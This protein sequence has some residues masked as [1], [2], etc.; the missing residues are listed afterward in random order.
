VDEALEAEGYIGGGSMH[1]RSTEVDGAARADGA[2]DNL[3][4][5]QTLDV[6]TRLVVVALVDDERY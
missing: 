6:T 1:Q 4:T 5:T 3:N 2:G